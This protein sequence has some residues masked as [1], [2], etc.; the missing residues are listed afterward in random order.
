MNRILPFLFL[1]VMLNACSNKKIINPQDYNAILSDNKRTEK[2]IKKINTE[3]I[4]WQNRLAKDTGSFVDMLQLASNHIKIFKTTGN[5]NELHTADSLYT[6]CLRKVRTTDPEIYF[7]Y[8]QNAITQHRFKDAWQSLML[9][10][11][12]G[13]NPFV[14]RLLK[15]D[16][17]MEIGLY[18]LASKNIE[19]FQDKNSFD[20]LIRKATLEAH[21]GRLDIA[22]ALMAKA[23]KE[24]ELKGKQ[25]LV[26]WAK[27][28]LADMYGHAGRVEDA[29]K[30]YVDVLK[31]DSNY[32]YALKGIAWIAFSHDHNTQE[33]K[34]ILYYILSQINLPDLYL[35][36]AE[37]ADWEKN[38]PEKDNCINKFLSIVENPANGNMYN[39]Y[40]ITIYTTNK[41]DLNKALTIAEKEVESR[42]TPETFDWLAWVYYKKG[43]ITKA[44]ELIKNNVIGKTFEPNSLLRTAYI[45]KSHGERRKSNKIFKECLT[46]SFELG[47]ITTAEIKNQLN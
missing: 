10:D 30:N 46:S 8:S 17:A 32:L 12:I 43:D 22:I 37:I 3:I 45:L 19:E 21:K 34:R 23:L 1:L 28:N 29:Y 4:F 13:V 11:S 33:A 20:Y 39:K 15:F 31:I 5:V 14:L 41:N 9:A 27:S 44:Y 26:L 16:A 38:K 47:P 6:I 24:V 36:L 40:L 2:Q 7:S 42:P 18:S 35:M 25:E